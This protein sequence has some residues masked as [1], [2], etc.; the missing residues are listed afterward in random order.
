M[1]L[2]FVDD[3]IWFSLDTTEKLRLGNECVI[4]KLQLSYL[5]THQA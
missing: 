5:Y 1:F 3:V 2:Q 4:V